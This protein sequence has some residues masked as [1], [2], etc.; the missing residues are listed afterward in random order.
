VAQERATVK[1]VAARAGVSAA[2]VSRVLSGDYPVA[3]STRNKV[4]R[5][6]R[7]LDYVANA[8]ARALKGSGTKM[9]AFV[10]EDVT[11][12]SFAMVAKG[13]E[14]QATAAGRLCLVCTTHGDPDRELAIVEAM[15]EQHADAV[16]LVGGGTQD[17]TYRHRMITI[18]RAL[19]KAGSRSVLAGRPPLGDDVPATDTPPPPAA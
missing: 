17:M 7:E 8:Q 19:E 12:P 11:G 14:Q 1:D 16:I 13:V 18:A 15:R 5:A 3:T 9:V 4:T 6:I 10:L 2:T